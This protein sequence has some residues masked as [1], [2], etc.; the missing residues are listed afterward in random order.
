MS[1]SMLGAPEPP[2]C[3]GVARLADSLTAPSPDTN[4]YV[5]LVWAAAL[6]RSGRL[7]AEQSR[8]LNR[9]PAEVWGLVD[10]D[11]WV[12]RYMACAERD[13][14]GRPLT[15]SWR[16]DWVSLQRRRRTRG[17]MPAG[18][19]ELLDRLGQFTWTPDDDRWEAMLDRT[20]DFAVAHGR[21]PSRSDDPAIAAWLAVQRFLLRRGRMSS[22][23]QAAL[24]N[25]PGWADS[26]DTPRV[27]GQWEG[28]YAELASFLSRAGGAYPDHRSTDP[29]EAALG[30]WAEHQRACHRRA[31]LSSARVQALES[32]PKWRWSS[33]DGVFDR[34]ICELRADLK[35][36]PISSDHHMYRWV[37]TQRRRH[38]E[39]RLTDDQ[40]KDLDSLGLLGDAVSR[41]RRCAA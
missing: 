40:I 32:L 10:R 4:D 35:G 14:A 24:E 15:G 38:R 37:V 21:M 20:A 12:R 26:L 5:S 33:R 3:K 13:F 9:L 19:V 16:T 8:Q 39:G 27:S 7:P 17:E 29:A 34:R 2:W 6:D 25:L 11:A 1:P 31:D 18:Q 22:E 41:R 23:R 30:R 36:G 28:R